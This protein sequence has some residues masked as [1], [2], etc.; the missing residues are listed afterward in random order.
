MRVAS[1]LILQLSIELEDDGRPWPHPWDHYPFHKDGKHVW[2]RYQ[3]I[4]AEQHEQIR[5]ALLRVNRRLGALAVLS[6]STRTRR[7]N[8][9][10]GPH[11][12][13][14]EPENP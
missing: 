12:H 10:S 13:F 11:S 1:K 2:L 7:W 4:D 14:V 5:H 3:D 8:H 6:E 9:G